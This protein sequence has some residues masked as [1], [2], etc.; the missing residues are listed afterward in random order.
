MPAAAAVPSREASGELVSGVP[1][2]VKMGA[3]QAGGG[4]R[5]HPGAAVEVAMAKRLAVR[6]TEQYTDLADVRALS[7]ILPDTDCVFR[8]VVAGRT[9]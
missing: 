2:V 6:A 7:C 9:S 4:E 5:G 1:Q 3:N 8:A